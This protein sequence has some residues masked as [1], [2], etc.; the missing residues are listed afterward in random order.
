M[1]WGFLGASR[2]GRQRVAAALRSQGQ[3]LV[4][5]AARDPE[6]AA[7]YARQQGFE[8]AEPSYEALLAAPDIGAVYLSLTTEQHVP[9][10]IRA[11]NAGKH[12]LCEK[13]L[14]LRADEVR[15]LIA[16]QARTGFQVMEAFVYPFHPQFGH[17]LSLVRSGALGNVLSVQATFHAHLGRPDDFRWRLSHGGGALLDVGCYCVSSIRRLLEQDPLWVSAQQHGAAEVDGTTTGLLAFAD[18]VAA[19]FTCSLESSPVQELRVLGSEAH[20]TLCRPFSSIDEPAQAI[21]GSHVHAFPPINPYEKMIEHFVQVIRQSAEPEL[22]LADSLEQS[23]T[24]DALRLSM[25]TGKQVALE[26]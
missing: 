18:G 20:L 15:A 2:I 9:W 12:V 10:A 7:A 14:A 25:G 23:R 22:P 1:R 24:L 4:A 17:A 19:T 5:V 3:T 6:R 26:G 13:P 21:V 8:R 11:L 16:A